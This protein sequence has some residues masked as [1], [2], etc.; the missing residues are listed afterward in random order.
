MGRFLTLCLALGVG[1]LLAT[2]VVIRVQLAGVRVGDVLRAR[3]E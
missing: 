3:D 2:L 1:L